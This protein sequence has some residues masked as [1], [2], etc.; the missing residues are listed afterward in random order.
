MTPD[1]Q[2]LD[3]VLRDCSAETMWCAD[4]NT[5]GYIPTAYKG[6]IISNRFDI[7]AQLQQNYPKAT[8]CDF[9]FSSAEA[10]TIHCIVFRIAKEKAVNLHIISEA[11]RLLNKGGKLVLIG[12]KNEGINSLCSKIKSSYDC[13]VVINKYK[14]QLQHIEIESSGVQTAELLDTDY[15]T[16]QKL[17]VNETEFYSKPGIFGWNK[18]DSGSKLLI[19]ALTLNK[20]DTENTTV[21]DLGCGYGYLSIKAKELGFHHINATDNNAAAIQA[22]MSNFEHYKIQ[23]EVF[24]DNHAKN[25]QTQYDLVLCNPPFHKGF[26]HTKN[27]TEVFTQQA[28]KSLKPNGQA[29]FVTNQFI[30]IEKIANKLFASTSLLLKKEGFKVFLFKK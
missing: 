18:T 28:F 24:A 1:I 16:S 11:F 15:F 9:N 6:N 19:E 26:D 23:G 8:F 25:H 21:L 4:E 22:C 20:P 30:G 7:I 10:A 3:Q 27:L 14:A 29:F 17:I 12:Y 5:A 2:L 13:D